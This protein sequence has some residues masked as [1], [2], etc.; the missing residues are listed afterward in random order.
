MIS[1]PLLK[2]KIFCETSLGSGCL[3]KPLFFFITIY[4]ALP[5]KFLPAKP[6]KQTFTEMGRLIM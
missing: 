5:F 2:V 6:V 3:T 1:V 4:M